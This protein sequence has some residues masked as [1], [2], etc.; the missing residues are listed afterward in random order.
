MADTASITRLLKMATP[1][2]IHRAVRRR[3]VRAQAARYPRRVVNRRY[4]GRRFSIHLADPVAEGW[5][6]RDWPALPEIAFLRASRL[7]PG[8]TV[9]D[10]GAHQAVVALMLAA[11]VGSAGRVV[12]VEAEPRNAE[13][14]RENLR[15]NRTSNIDVL[16]AAVDEAGG[17]VQFAEGLNGHVDPHSRRMGHI[18]V[19]AVTI[20][21]LA[22]RYGDPDVLFLDVEGYEARALCGARETLTRARP[23]V[24]LEVHIGCGLEAAGGS[25][26][27]VTAPLRAAG[28][29][30]F[31]AV[32]DLSCDYRFEPL[33]AS[34]AAPQQRSYLIGLSG[35]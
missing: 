3:R 17:V 2:P 33:G 23:D 1:G 4:G 11:E 18:S 19:P 16:H 10:L 26:Q 5:Y 29:D 27:K 12:A 34:D 14:A 15:L 7:R 13:V 28:Y 30:L 25:W 35:R 9:F 32:G 20:D 6:D 21:Q 24:F 22:A 31:V 8:A